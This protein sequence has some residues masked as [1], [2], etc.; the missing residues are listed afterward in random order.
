MDFLDRPNLENPHKTPTS[1][2]KPGAKRREFAGITGRP[3]LVQNVEDGHIA[4]S[5]QHMALSCPPHATSSGHS[6]SHRD[7]CAPPSSD[8]SSE[9]R[10][11]R[12]HLEVSVWDVAAQQAGETEGNPVDLV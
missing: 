4:L 11:A 2:A 1:Q 8:H 10:C 12:S 9:R 7:G 6:A 5:S 3:E